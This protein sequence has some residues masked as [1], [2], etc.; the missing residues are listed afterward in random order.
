VIVDLDATTPPVTVLSWSRN[1]PLDGIVTRVNFD[2][3]RSMNTFV[4]SRVHR[5]RKLQ[6]NLMFSSSLPPFPDGFRGDWSSL[7]KF[8][9][10]G[11]DFSVHQINHPE[12]ISVQLYRMVITI[13]TQHALNCLS[14]HV[15]K[16]LN[17]CA[18]RQSRQK[19][20]PHHP[21]GMRIA[22]EVDDKQVAAVV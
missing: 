11:I 12:S 6:F 9:R 17:R 5:S 16:A 15:S 22:N 20:L 19:P 13:E 14:N 8:W 10:S 18:T 4:H 7:F 21:L 3:A 1:L 2:R